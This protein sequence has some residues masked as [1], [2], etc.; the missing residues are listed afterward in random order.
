VDIVWIVEKLKVNC[1]GPLRDARGRRRNA[2]TIGNGH[3]LGVTSET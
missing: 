1:C 2:F 3:H